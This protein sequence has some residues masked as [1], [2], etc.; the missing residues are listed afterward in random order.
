MFTLI[1]RVILFEILFLILNVHI[2]FPFL[3]FSTLLTEECLL[4]LFLFNFYSFIKQELRL[5]QNK[6]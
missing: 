3:K 5:K 1:T 6:S 4:K 2:S